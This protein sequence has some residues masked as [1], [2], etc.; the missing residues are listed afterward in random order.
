MAFYKRG[1]LP[2]VCF[3]CKTISV[4]ISLDVEQVLSVRAGDKV[5][6]YKQANLTVDLFTAHWNL[7]GHVLPR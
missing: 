1:T 6:T 5:S 7:S 2:T 4:C 3:I